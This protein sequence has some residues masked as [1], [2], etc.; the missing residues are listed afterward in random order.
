[1]TGDGI[2]DSPA[3]SAA[4]A[5]IAIS[6]G[7]EIAREIADITIEGHDLYEIVTL[8]Q[9]EQPAYGTDPEELPLHRGNQYSAHLPGRGR[10]DPAY[11]ICSAAQYIHTCY[12]PEKH[13]GPDEVKESGKL[14]E[15][16]V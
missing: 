11:Y 6:D 15:T 12:Q 2:N 4:D 1:M 14:M 16:V 13:A 3:L 7:A 10:R 9:S 8:K 5:G